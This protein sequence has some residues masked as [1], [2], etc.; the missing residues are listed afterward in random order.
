MTQ[1]LVELEVEGQRYRSFVSSKLTR[2]MD[3]F[4]DRWEVA[5]APR[6]NQRTSERLVEVGNAKATSTETQSMRTRS[7]SPAPPPGEAAS[8][9]WSIARPG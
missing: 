6:E 8:V 2:S 9:T 3:A 5:F 1:P 7:T 4:A